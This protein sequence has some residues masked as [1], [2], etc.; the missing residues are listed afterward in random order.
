MKSLEKKYKVSI[1]NYTNTLPFLYGL[2]HSFTSNEIEI[3]SDHPADCAKKLFNKE[4]DIGL[5][6]V[7]VLHSMNDYQIVTDFCI[8]S[9]NKVD[10]VSLYSQVPL[11]EISTILLDYQSRTS[12]TLVRILCR[13]L[14]KISPQFLKGEIGFENNIKGKT[15]GVVIGDRTFHLKNKFEYTFDLAENWR[16]LTNLPFVFACWVCT[17]KLSEEFLNKFN[18]ALKFGVS[19]TAEAVNTISGSILSKQEYN[20]YLTERINYNFN[21]EK[22]AALKLFLEKLV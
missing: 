12:V 2:K 9:E 8:G 3:V 18:E 13:E 7:S 10:S 16:N 6:P 22:R 17:N 1:V 15:A 21:T 20:F 4:T 5:I 19:H 11:H 14:W